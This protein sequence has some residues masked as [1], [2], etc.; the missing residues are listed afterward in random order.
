M[1]LTSVPVCLA[2]SLNCRGVTNS[3]LQPPLPTGFG[4]RYSSRLGGSE[5]SILPHLLLYNEV[6]VSKGE[7][8][9]AIKSFGRCGKQLMS[10]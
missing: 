4:L 6:E 10:R 7:A 8:E 5:L 3:Y 1:M 2:T 9:G